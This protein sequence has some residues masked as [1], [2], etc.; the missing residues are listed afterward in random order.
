MEPYT[1]RKDLI[2]DFLRPRKGPWPWPLGSLLKALTG[3]GGL[4]KALQ[5]PLYNQARSARHLKTL[6]IRR[7]ITKMPPRVVP[8]ISLNRAL[9]EPYNNQ[10]RS[11]RHL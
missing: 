4:Y 7:E 1:A 5:G 8:K 9:I 10:A 3:M 2:T 6:K 11:A